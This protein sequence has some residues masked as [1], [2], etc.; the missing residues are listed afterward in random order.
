M[1][2]T[3]ANNV[4]VLVPNDQAPAETE[5]ERESRMAMEGLGQKLL[6]SWRAVPKANARPE[7]EE[8]QIFAAVESDEPRW[9]KRSRRRAIL[10][11]RMQ[12]AKLRT[13][14]QA[15]RKMTPWKLQQRASLTTATTS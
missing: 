1:M 14:H 5:D 3:S 13:R 12:A 9:S 8:V 6:G 11:K 15:N 4:L 7:S 10:M 2:N